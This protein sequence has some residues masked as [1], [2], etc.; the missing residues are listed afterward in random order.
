MPGLA[1]SW[2]GGRGGQAQRVAR[3]QQGAK[4]RVL[5]SMSKGTAKC[6][7]NPAT[8]CG[9]GE[10]G[11]ERGR[12]KDNGGRGEGGGGEGVASYPPLRRA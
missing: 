8:L 2:G 3:G 7:V 4:K 5:S 1:C 12:E 11:R 6:G 10:S 9:E